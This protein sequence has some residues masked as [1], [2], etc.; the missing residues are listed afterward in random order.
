MQP[1]IQAGESFCPLGLTGRLDERRD[2]RE[3]LR[4]IGRDLRQEGLPIFWRDK[5]EAGE[6]HSALLYVNVARRK[7]RC[8]RVGSGSRSPSVDARRYRARTR[9][10]C[11]SQEIEK[12][13]QR[14]IFTRASL[15]LCA[16]RV[17]S[18]WGRR[19]GSFVSGELK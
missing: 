19:K 7:P 6:G 15:H 18:T 2:Q 16:H 14:S 8:D 12:G 11:A 4:R 17:Q 10:R 5:R 13:G 1:V 3:S 9:R